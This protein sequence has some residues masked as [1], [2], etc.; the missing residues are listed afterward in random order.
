MGPANDGQ[1]KCS[2]SAGWQIGR[3]QVIKDNYGVDVIAI[4][5]TWCTSCIP[6]GPLSLSGFNCYRRDRQ[7][8]RQH[9][10]ITCYV[11][12]SIPAEHWPELNQPVLDTH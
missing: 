6:D 9:G 7:D 8:G 3:D 5:E 12:D 4:T 10:G 11:R 1:Y 2:W